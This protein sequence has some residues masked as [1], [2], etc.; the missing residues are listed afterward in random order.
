MSLKDNTPTTVDPV[1]LF[2]HNVNDGGNG[3]VEIRESAHASENDVM[4]VLPGNAGAKLVLW[5]RHVIR[6]DR[7]RESAIALARYAKLSGELAEANRLLVGTD[8][9]RQIA[10]TAE[11]AA[12]SALR[13]KKKHDKLHRRHRKASRMVRDLKRMIDD[14]RCQVV[15]LAKQPRPREWF[16]KCGGE[17]KPAPTNLRPDPPAAHVV[18]PRRAPG[19]NR[20]PIAWVTSY[21]D[22][23]PNL[24]WSLHETIE[25]ANKEVRF[26]YERDRVWLNIVPVFAPEAAS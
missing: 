24:C 13:W 26:I 18:E 8:Y 20:E 7:N 22:A 4:M 9:I 5:L 1:E 11:E 15:Y 3:R 14:L 12:D 6:M 25:G 2:R 16:G 23:V 19:D 17:N 21:P 10:T